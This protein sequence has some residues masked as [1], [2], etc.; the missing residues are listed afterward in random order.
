MGDNRGDGRTLRLY[1]PP[2]KKHPPKN[3]RIRGNF[4]QAK[5]CKIK[6]VMAVMGVIARTFRFYPSKFTLKKM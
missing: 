3:V 4:K 6:V 5:Q 1:P 2:I